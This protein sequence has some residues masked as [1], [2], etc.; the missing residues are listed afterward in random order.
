MTAKSM[1]ETS[2]AA[3]T[4][5]RDLV[6]VIPDFLFESGARLATLRL[7][8]S[9]YGTLNAAR[10]NAILLSPNASGLR[11]WA[12]PFIREGG[13][14]D[15]ARFC[16]IA[17]DA[18]GGGDSSKPSDGLGLDFPHYSVGDIVS[19]QAHLVSHG[20]ELRTLQAIA[21]PSMASLVGFEWAARFPKVA[22]GLA[23]WTP[24]IR[25]DALGK[26][27]IEGLVSIITLDNAY[28][29]GR[30]RSQPFEGMRRAAS[31]FFPH[32]L[33]REFLERIPAG[34]RAGMQRMLSDTW[35]VNWDAND[36]IY[37]YRAIAGCDL[38]A[39]HGGPEGLATAVRCPALLVPCTSD[40]LF[41]MAALRPF[42]ERLREVTWAPLQSDKG[43]FVAAQPPG[44]SEFDFFD[45]TTAR[46][47]DQLQR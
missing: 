28:E 31:M 21:G 34:E 29:G 18:I 24:G 30:Y 16:I 25:C 23:L 3:S 37:R 33:S 4:S 39:Q 35:A 6:H 10:D 26:A 20:L 45:R 14:F 19:A 46:F 41:T 36:L 7:G 15:P 2:I 9:I 47:L 17:A 38:P 5:R 12:T 22:R 43:H 8:Y 1:A 27:I 13:A 40:Q 42:A 11:D 44:T 32:L